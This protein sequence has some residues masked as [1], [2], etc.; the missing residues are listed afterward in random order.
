MLLSEASVRIARRHRRP[1]HARRRARRAPLRALAPRER[2]GAPRGGGRA[3]AGSPRTSATSSSSS[4]ARAGRSW[5]CSSSAT[6]PAPTSRSRRPPRSPRSCTGRCTCGG[7][8]CSAARAPSSR[9]TSTPPSGWRARRSRSASAATPRTP[10]TTTRWRCS[11][12]AASRAAS[13]RSRRRSR[14]F[15]EMYPAIPAWRC[16]QALMH[17]ELGRHE[18]ARE[19]FESVAAAGFDALPRDANF[20]IAVTLLAEVCGALGDADRA[21]E[22]LPAA[23][24]ARR[25]QRARRARGELQRLGLAAARD[26]RGR[27]RAVGG[28]RAAASRRRSRCT[29][30]WAPGRGW[31]A[32]SWRGRRCCWPAASRATR[33]RRG[34]RLAEAI[35]LADAL[36]M[37]AVAERARALVA[38][39]EPVRSRA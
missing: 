16:C 21:A 3:A 33:P 30:G 22:L 34:P 36:G 2:R 18:E 9:A 12:S 35:V 39:G 26:P 10:C 24:A 8:R 37:V 13:A 7:R 27:A 20:L 17:I 29:C 19:A 6:S 5:T 15:I 32:R 14:S 23:G 11:T 4:K 25:A 1:G 38:G 28:G 31:R